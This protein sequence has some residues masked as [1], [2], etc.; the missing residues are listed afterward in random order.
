MDRFGNWVA[1]Q[2]LITARARAEV[3]D[4]Q[5]D[6]EAELL[7]L[8]WNVPWER[9]RRER[10]LRVHT[11]LTL[12]LPAAWL[13]ELHLK[14]H[15]LF[16]W[17][18]EEAE[19]DVQAMAL[20]RFAVLQVALRLYQLDHGRAAS[21]LSALVPAYLPA[22]PRDPYTGAPFGYRLSAGEQ[23]TYRPLTLPGMTGDQPAPG[24]RGANA[25]PPGLAALEMRIDSPTRPKVGVR[26]AARAAP[27]DVAAGE[28]VLWSAGPD[29]TDDGG[30]HPL[31]PEF[32]LTRE[33]WIVV[34]PVVA[35][36]PK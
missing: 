34:I 33:D 2:R 20:R 29:R 15:W 11:D 28:G 6:S 1:Q 10:I 23:L 12:D 27:V 5:A 13:S 21:D 32:S 19:R 36:P 14:R 26:P 9:A 7:A 16:A 3:S 17:T 4:P 30:R 8:A 24:G 35:R 31:S 18:D 22:V 25:P